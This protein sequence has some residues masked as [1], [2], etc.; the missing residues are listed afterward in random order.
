MRI[1][2]NPAKS[3]DFVPQPERVTVAIVTYIPTLGGYYAQSLDVL[4]AC[5]GSIW[6][7][8]HTPYD[9]MVFDNGSCEQVRN[10]LTG[11]QEQGRIQYLMLSEKNVGKAGAWNIIF[12]AAPG[13][14]VAYADSDVYHYPGWLAPQLELFETF[15]NLGMVTGMPMWTPE[16]FS[17]STIEWAQKN[18]EVG[19]ERGRFLSWEDYWRHSQSLGAE[20][21][22]ARA[23][24]NANETICVFHAGKQYY[25]GAAHF[26]FVASKKVLQSVLPIPSRRPMGEV[27]LLDIALNE[28]G[29]LRLTTPDWWVQHIGNTLGD[30]FKP[31]GTESTTRK[32]KSPRGGIWKSKPV[33]KIAR[34]LYHLTFEILYKD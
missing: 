14:Y 1:G 10:Y 19:L 30:E 34:W 21:E 16:E 18:P 25:V 9:L 8:T 33:Q 32:F 15:P 27:R 5:L 11:A 31:R 17:S 2:Q 4:K 29:Y 22:K 12:A 28:R 23:H 6:K 24:Y 3:I 20:E 7:N 13:E 26:Q